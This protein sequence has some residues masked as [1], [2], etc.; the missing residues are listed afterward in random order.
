MK[1]NL[2]IF[3]RNLRRPYRNC[4][5]LVPIDKFCGCVL[6]YILCAHCCTHIHG[7]ICASCNISLSRH[8]FKET[9]VAVKPFSELAP[10]FP[11]E[12][13]VLRW[14]NHAFRPPLW[15]DSSLRLAVLYESFELEVSLILCTD[16]DFRLVVSVSWFNPESKAPRSLIPP[17]DRA[18]FMSWFRSEFN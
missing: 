17:S 3:G 15:G 18:T 7:C 14:L 16:S 8:F 12:S 10:F 1:E 11:F 2:W 6:T 5:T 9:L 4:E 13:F